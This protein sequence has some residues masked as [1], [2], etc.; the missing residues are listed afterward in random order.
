MACA[1]KVF[2]LVESI[3]NQ[4]TM[5]D[6]NQASRQATPSRPVE[7]TENKESK[8][9]LAGFMPNDFAEGLN[10]SHKA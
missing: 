2:V 9:S 4:T 6:F 8:V 1:V 5:A 7:T 10:Q 3:S